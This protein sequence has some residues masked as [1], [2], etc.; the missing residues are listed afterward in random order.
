MSNQYETL[1][2]F[3]A[4]FFFGLSKEIRVGLGLILGLLHI[5]VC[6]YKCEIHHRRV[7]LISYSK[8][9]VLC[10][11]TRSHSPQSVI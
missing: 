3:T 4:D 6:A 8:L 11:S 2:M 10:A 9:L 7:W 5:H 1:S